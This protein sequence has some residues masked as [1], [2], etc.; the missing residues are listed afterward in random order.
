MVNYMLIE[1]KWLNVGGWGWK[2][3]YVIQA[4]Q[5]WFGNRI[6][7]YGGRKRELIVFLLD[8]ERYDFEVS[9]WPYSAIQRCSEKR[10]KRFRLNSTPVLKHNPWCRIVIYFKHGF[11][12]VRLRKPSI[13]GI[14]SSRPTRFYNDVRSV[15]IWKSDIYLM[16]LTVCFNC[17][18]TGNDSFWA[19]NW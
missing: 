1:H 18:R 4:N 10:K 17:C 8:Q 2:K 13:R 9:E 11:H 6:H 16:F 7:W 15:I 5:V 3:G 19:M 14:N 12:N